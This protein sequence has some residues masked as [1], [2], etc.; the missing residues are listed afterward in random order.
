MIQAR[1]FFAA[2]ALV[3]AACQ[4][5]QQHATNVREAQQGGDKLTVGTV[6]REIKVGMTN[7]EVVQV[8]GSPNMVTTDEARREQWVYDKIATDTVYSGSSGGVS[9]LFLGGAVIGA[10]LA[11]GGVAPSYYSSAGARST[12]QRTL[13]IIIKYDENQRVRD[14]A[15]RSSSF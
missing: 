14:F 11:G 10:G 8:L 6:Q 15:Y 2:A 12:S 4:S 1:I 9:T 7:A 3:V 5:P 13:T